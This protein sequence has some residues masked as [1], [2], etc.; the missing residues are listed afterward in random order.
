MKEKGIHEL[1][2]VLGEKCIEIH[3][4][5]APLFNMMEQYVVLGNVIHSFLDSM[6][7]Q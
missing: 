5:H 7:W 2:N 6:M 4:Y 3:C 1:I